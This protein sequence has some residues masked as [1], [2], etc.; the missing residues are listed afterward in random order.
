MNDQDREDTFLI[1]AALGTDL[2]TSAASASDDPRKRSGCLGALLLV[3]IIAW[4][5]L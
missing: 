5:L 2:L 1:N 4:V 3:A